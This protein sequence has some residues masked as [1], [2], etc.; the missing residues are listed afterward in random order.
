[1]KLSLG[2]IATIQAG[3]QFRGRVVHD[4]TGGVPVIQMKDYDPVHGIDV[5]GMMTIRTD[6]VPAA[7]IARTGDVLFLSRGQ[8]L[9]ATVVTHEVEGAIVS[10]YF[11]ILRPEAD[12]A[13][14]GFLA[15]YINQTRFQNQLRAVAKGTD[16]PLV[17]KTDIQDLTVELPPI[18]IQALVARLDELSRREHRLLEAIAEKRSALIQALTQEAA[19]SGLK[20]EGTRT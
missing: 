12:I 16:T 4:P 9:T 10:G 13:E 20:P 15:W 3:Y 1:M 6:T 19:R 7:C 14:P 18:N 5:D 17:S 2:E 11:F 8:R